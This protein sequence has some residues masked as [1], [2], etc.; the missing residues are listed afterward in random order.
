MPIDAASGRSKPLFLKATDSLS[1]I[2]SNIYT[3]AEIDRVNPDYSITPPSNLRLT[4][5]I[6]KNINPE[7]IFPTL[8]GAVDGFPL[9]VDAHS[10]ATG[11]INGDGLDDVFMGRM[12]PDAGYELLQQ[13]DGSFIFNR[14]DVYKKLHSWPLTLSLIH[15]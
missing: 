9:A 3:A 1:F 6:G 13:E 14:Q 12:Q 4:Q 5:Q 15:I 11:D 8:P 7:D 10:M 2:T